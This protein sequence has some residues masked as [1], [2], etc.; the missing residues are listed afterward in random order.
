MDVRQSDL[1]A[2]ARCPL[3][4][5]WQNIEML[6]RQQGG[7]AIFGSVIHHCVLYLETEHDLE[8]AVDWFKRLWRQPDLLD[9]T[10][11]VDYYERGRSWTRF[12]EKGEDILRRWWNIIQWETDLV[13]AREYG[14][15]VPIGN[16]HMLNGTLD[17]IT[18][19]WRAATEEWIVLISDYKGLALDT[20]LV[21]PDGW[22]TMGAVQVGDQVIGGH[23]RPC[24]VTAKSQV[25]LRDCYRI[26]FDDG[27]SVVADNEHLWQVHTDGGVKV[28]T[29]ED[30]VANLRNPATGQRHLR[31]PNVVME[32][33]HAALPVDPYVLGAWL[34]DGAASGGVITKPLPA[35][36]QEIAR[37]GYAVGP[38]IRSSRCETHTV[39]GLVTQLRTLGV[40]KNK[41]IPSEYLR[42][43]AAQRLDLMRGIMD[44]DGHWN[45]KRK[46]C[47]LNTTD[48]RFARQVYELAV[49]LGWKA[50]TF[51]TTATGFG[52]SVPAW[53][54][55]F[56]PVDEEVFLARRPEGYRAEAPAKS[57]R[58]LI[59]SVEQVPTVETQCIAVD[60]PEST[61]LCGEQMVET[62]NTA[63][64]TPTYGYLEED[65]QFTAY[66]YASTRPE[67]WE[68]LIPGDPA[69]GIEL[70]EKYAGYARY[71]EWV[72]LVD[73]KR[74]DAGIRTQR[75]YNRLTMAV[76][77]MADSIAMRIFV[78][79]IS[80]E[81]C[82]FCDYRSQCGLPE[83]M[84]PEGW[85]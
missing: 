12:L 77:A 11:Q 10:Y 62:H 63:A 16:G 33:R 6:P 44:T 41:H 8:G 57:R 28:L 68:P 53:Q 69:R 17:K 74:M 4:Y 20:P 31:I 59:V 23:G 60:S 79:N 71:G 39:Y 21:T 64:K 9:P 22:T 43:S 73:S 81:S 84:E 7:S 70:W 37:R 58:R 50:A 48:E 51:A 83:L 80:G 3:L 82:R 32:L 52:K 1:K 24:V 42:A 36:F 26:T 85:W 13:L 56:T 34:G 19:R 29:T 55:W 46:R 27:S 78:P 61:Y 65:L 75:H 38:E 2:W 76:N 40:F 49:S 18:I 67:F 15:A 47:V 66:A 14:F 45:S 54:T 5:R 30:L 35:L 25:H 72:Q